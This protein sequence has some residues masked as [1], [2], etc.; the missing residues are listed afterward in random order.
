VT[1]WS[2]TAAPPREDDRYCRMSLPCRNGWAS[3][4][5]PRRAPPKGRV[6]RPRRRGVES[7]G[8]L[9]R[10]RSARDLV[11]LRSWKAGPQSGAVLH[12]A[13]GLGRKRR[14]DRTSAPKR[15]RSSRNRQTLSRILVLPVRGCYKIPDVIGLRKVSESSRD[16]LPE[17]VVPLLL[18]QSDSTC[19]GKAGLPY[20]YLER[21]GS[22]NVVLKKDAASSPTG[23]LVVTNEQTEGRG[24]LG[25]TWLSQAGKDLA[26]SV[27][28]RPAMP[29]EHTPLLS[30]AAGVATAEVLEQLPGLA[31]RVRVKWPNDVLLGDKK[32]CGILLESYVR[33]GR[34]DW[35]VAGIGLN[36]NSDPAAMMRHLTSAQREEWRGK[37]QPTSLAAELGSEVPRGALLADLLARLSCRWMRPDPP[38]LLEGLGAFDALLGR[39]VEVFAGPPTDLLVVAGE[40]AGIG[41]AGELLVRDLHGETVRVVAGEVTLRT[42]E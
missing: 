24:R 4:G 18:G 8:T 31:G 26:F 38:R 6:S 20:R 13:A 10:E 3:S 39:R 22:T 17:A 36:V 1:I 14:L 21:C 5:L 23:T 28:L 42:S 12:R 27:L 29:P 7:G 35:V 15:C 30:L 32:V 9:R 41:P 19:P 40:A 2:A 11:I 34:L 25:R 33:G 37:P 16:L